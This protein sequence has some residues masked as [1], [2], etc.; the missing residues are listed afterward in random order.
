[1]AKKH[2]CTQAQLALAWS[3][4]NKD[5][6]VALLGFTKLEQIHENFKAVEILQKWT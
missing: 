6:S 1:L 3:I 2:N 4:A 5:V